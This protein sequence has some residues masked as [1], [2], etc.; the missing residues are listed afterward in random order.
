MMNRRQFVEALGA[1]ATAA[2]L[3]TLW[4]GAGRAQEMVRIEG[5]VLWISGEIMVVAPY[6]VVA[7]GAGAINVDL[8]QVDQ[9]E[10]ARLVTGYPV[11]VTGTVDDA[12]NRV[13]AT[14]VQHL[15]L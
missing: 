11:V 13:I 6:T 5:R 2:L 9:D 4:I 14:S 12:R 10:Y 7:F 8:S 3:M 15:A 1:V